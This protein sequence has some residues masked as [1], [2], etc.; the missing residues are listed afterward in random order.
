VPLIELPENE[1]S[2]TLYLQ[3]YPVSKTFG[4]AQAMPRHKT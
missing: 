1:F 2:S 3:G 4:I